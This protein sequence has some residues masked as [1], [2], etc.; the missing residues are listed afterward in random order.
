[1]NVYDF[2]KT[3]YD[4]DCSIDFYFFC[5]KKHPKILIYIFKQIYGIFLKKIKKID[6]TKMKEYFF[7]FLKSLDDIDLLIENFWDKKE[8]KI[9]KWYL[10]IK[11]E[12]DL[13]ISA[14]PQF[15]INP[16][17]ERLKISKPLATIM[18]VKTGKISGKNCKGK[19][20]VNRFYS[21]YPQKDILKFYSDSM[22]DLPLKEIA[23]ESYLVKKDKI[24]AWK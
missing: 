8:G 20:K 9:K 3:I 10:N 12:D 14:S 15:L 2:D 24:S 23:K 19:E 21:E 13:I 6:T 16:I 4:G 11:R 17:C 5:L 18:D 1:M 7:S 22:T